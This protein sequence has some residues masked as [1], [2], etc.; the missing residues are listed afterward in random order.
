MSTNIGQAAENLVSEYLENL[1]FEILHKNWKTR[2]C[3]IDIVAKRGERV[4]F[5]EVKYRKSHLQGTGLEYITQTKAKQLKQAAR[6][7]ISENEWQG[8]YQIDAA[9]ITGALKLSNLE[10]V[11]SAVED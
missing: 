6:W 4:H 3:E 7:W 10:L 8:D 1:G 5:I 2:W 9:G 11:W